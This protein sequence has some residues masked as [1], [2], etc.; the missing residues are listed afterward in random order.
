MVVSRGFIGAT[1]KLDLTYSQFLFQPTSGWRDG[2]YYGLLF[3]ATQ[4]RQRE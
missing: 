1:Q 4:E 3:Q 2:S